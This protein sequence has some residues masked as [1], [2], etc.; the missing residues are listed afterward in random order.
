MSLHSQELYN[1]LELALST[2]IVGDWAQFRDKCVKPVEAAQKPNATTYEQKMASKLTDELQNLIDPYLLKRKKTDQ[3][4]DSI[5]P[6]H[7][8]DV[9]IKLSLKQRQLYSSFVTGKM[10]TGMVDQGWK[11]CLP[12]IQ[13]LR[14]L[15]NHPLLFLKNDSQAAVQSVKAEMHNMTPQAIIAQSPKLQLSSTAEQVAF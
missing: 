8:F 13:R 2:D 7:Q 3:M 11:C 1:L 4:E 6:S 9:W 14:Q 15:I 5:H 10:H 12:A